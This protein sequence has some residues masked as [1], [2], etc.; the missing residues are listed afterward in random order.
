MLSPS[1][2]ILFQASLLRGI[3]PKAINR[4]SN[5]INKCRSLQDLAATDAQLK[6]ALNENPSVEDTAEE[7]LKFASSEGVFLLSNNDERY[8]KLLAKT[9]DAPYFL[10]VKGNLTVTNEPTIA[11]VGSRV[12][13][14]RS[15][16]ITRR[17]AAYCTV[18]GYS[19]LSGL[20]EGCDWAAHLGTLQHGGT[21]LAVLPHGICTRTSSERSK[22]MDRIIQEDGA[23]VSQFALSASPHKGSFISRDKVQSG[24]SSLTILVESKTDGGSLHACRA[25]L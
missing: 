8:P 24:M 3:G 10:F 13:T 18:K 1:D 21:T 20:A 22:L 7:Q 6:K 11:I 25:A 5:K 2:L 15:L 12:A 23:L 17:L 9:S 4:L 19:V 16:E 14:K